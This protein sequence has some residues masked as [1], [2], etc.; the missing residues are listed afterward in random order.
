L[1]L[2]IGRNLQEIQ[3]ELN[4]LAAGGK[5][6]ELT[7]VSFRVCAARLGFTSRTGSFAQPDEWRRGWSPQ[8]G[9]DCP[10]NSLR[11]LAIFLPLAF[12]LGAPAISQ[13][14]A[15]TVAVTMSN[16]KF[17]PNSL[18][19]RAGVPTVIH[20]VNTAGGGHNFTAPQFFAAA[21]V[22]PASQPL[23]HDGTVEVPKHSAVDVEL[24]PAAGQYPLKC[25]H[26]LHS[27]FGMKG[28]ITV[29]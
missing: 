28:T 5:K 9:K 16:F 2:C 11:S 24:V 19:L 12:G 10:M 20:L 4:R 7:I 29:R 1:R 13:P 22:A 21:R 8:T 25:S 17:E 27:A 14:Q 26:T 6:G 3:R 15:A 18:Q 23:V